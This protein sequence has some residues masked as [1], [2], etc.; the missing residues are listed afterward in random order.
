MKLPAVSLTSTKLVRERS[1]IQPG[2]ATFPVELGLE[3]GRN[4]SL[5]LIL[6]FAFSI[7]KT[8]NRCFL[9]FFSTEFLQEKE[10]FTN[11]TGTGKS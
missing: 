2:K 9:V 10:Y 3:P 7:F 1:N 4:I 6:G 11:F 8:S 5:L